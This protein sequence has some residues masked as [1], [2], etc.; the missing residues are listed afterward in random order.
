VTKPK[1]GIVGFGN[2]S[3]LMVQHLHPYADIVVSSRQLVSDQASW[4]CSFGSTSEVLAQEIIVPSVPAQ[5][6]EEY[7][8]SN[9]DLV[10]P[11]SLVI[12][13]CSVKVKPVD[14]LQRVLPPSVQIIATHPLFGPASAKN[15]LEAQK[16]M[17]APTRVREEVY[18]QVKNFFSDTL[19]LTLIE[20]TPEE[21]DQSMA[22]VLGLSHY[23][24]RVVQHMNIPE[25][26]L[27]TLA[28]ANLLDMK[29]VQGSDSWELFQS[30]MLE[31]PYA[32]K[33][34]DD[35]QAASTKLDKDLGLN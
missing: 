30:I 13:V 27:T 35:F 24:G 29:R 20:C 23:I 11:D 25:T 26:N 33:V 8:V 34:H 1:I 4:P 16:I 15:G 5:L 22:Y 7:F 2:F 6:L 12:D 19:K 17:V 28:Y 10:R 32:Q 31:N 18:R 21:H 9:F 14:V 3:K